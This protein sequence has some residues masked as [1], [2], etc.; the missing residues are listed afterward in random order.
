MTT[1]SRKEAN[2]RNQAAY[3]ERMRKAGYEQVTVWIQP[4]RKKILQ[5][6]AKDLLKAPESNP[7]YMDDIEGYFNNPL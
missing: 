1:N 4:E 6:I 7:Y 2:R 3:K 5:S